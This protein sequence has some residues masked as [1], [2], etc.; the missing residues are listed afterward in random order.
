MPGT[1]L[2]AHGVYP[3]VIELVLNLQGVAVGISRGQTGRKTGHS[4][5]SSEWQVIGTEGGDSR[6][7]RR[8]AVEVVNT[9][10]RGGVKNRGS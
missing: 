3:L 6:G 5:G 10:G 8:E 2:V 7:I 9:T 1:A 4:G